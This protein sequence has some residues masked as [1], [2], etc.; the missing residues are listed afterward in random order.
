[1]TSPIDLSRIRED[2]GFRPELPCA[3]AQERSP[4]EDAMERAA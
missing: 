3:D 2:S 4:K 1:M